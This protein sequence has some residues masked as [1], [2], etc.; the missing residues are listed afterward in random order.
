MSNHSAL[1][2]T[3]EDLSTALSNVPDDQRTW[4]KRAFSRNAAHAPLVLHALRTNAQTRR[5]Y[6]KC[7]AHAYLAQSASEMLP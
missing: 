6:R 3:S 7:C 5:S 2:T 4:V 1:P